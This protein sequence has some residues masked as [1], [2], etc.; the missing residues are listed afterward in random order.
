VNEGV[1]I[2]TTTTPNGVGVK[3]GCGAVSDPGGTQG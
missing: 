3:Q 2:S 1:W